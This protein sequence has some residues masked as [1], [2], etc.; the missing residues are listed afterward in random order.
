M[1]VRVG[2]T[3]ESSFAVSDSAYWT[4]LTP[5]RVFLD[6]IRQTSCEGM[7]DRISSS[8]LSG[9]FLAKTKCI[10]WEHEGFTPKSRFWDGARLIPSNLSSPLPPW[11]MLCKWPASSFPE[12]VKTL[13][14]RAHLVT[15]P[16]SQAHVILLRRRGE[17][18]SVPL[19][20][21]KR[22]TNSRACA[23]LL[24]GTGAPVLDG[25]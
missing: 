23:P 9:D 3:G 18:R 16:P 25:S 21:G 17:K 19:G 22:S 15:K 14:L 7:W 1:A 10:F 20:S 24:G 8:S 13:R 4:K 6:V 2:S 11:V 5:T 12:Q